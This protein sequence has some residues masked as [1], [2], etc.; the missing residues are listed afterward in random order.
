MAD[1]CSLASPIPSENESSPDSFETDDDNATDSS[2]HT[3]EVAE[4]DEKS[5]S[6]LPCSPISWAPSSPPMVLSE[7][8][9][10][11]CRRC[12]TCKAWFLDFEA[13]EKHTS[14]RNSL[15]EYCGGT[16]SCLGIFDHARDVSH[17]ECFVPG[18]DFVPSSDSPIEESDGVRGHVWE[19]HTLKG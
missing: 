11:D 9:A 19:E 4:V 10:H 14:E 1:G 12:Q 6:P 16:F 8:S 15:C 7:R 17:F 18:C 2:H 5:K 13:W 3:G